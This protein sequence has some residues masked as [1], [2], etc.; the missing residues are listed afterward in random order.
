VNRLVAYY[1]SSLLAYFVG[2]WRERRALARMDAPITY[3]GVVLDVSWMSAPMRRVFLGGHYEEGERALCRAL[4]GPEDSVL[5]IGSAIGFLSLYCLAVVGVRDVACVEA[6]PA[7]CERLERNYRLNGRRPVLHQVCLA[8]EDG[9][10]VLGRRG[11]F[12]EDS[13][14]PAAVKPAGGAEAVR[15]EPP[16]AAPSPEMQWEVQGVTAASLFARAPGCTAV[17]CDVEG[18]E[19]HLRP[20]DLPARVRT[21]I[22]ELHPGRLG[23]VAAY[24]VLA[25]FVRAGFE[26][27]DRAGDVWALRRA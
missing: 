25:G 24:G 11:E 20:A 9:P 19:V 15:E 3:E 14:L 17:V 16:A 21:L 7:T 22:L 6:N 27:Q 4:L 10:V 26:I 2:R 12:W 1:R 18:A 23:P 5:E 8:A 13:T